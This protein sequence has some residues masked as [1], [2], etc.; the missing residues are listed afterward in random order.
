VSDVLGTLSIVRHDN[1]KTCRMDIVEGLAREHL[2]FITH[3]WS[4]ELAVAK[5]RAVL[6][7]AAL[8]QARRNEAAWQEMQRIYGAPD[9]HWDWDDISSTTGAMHR[10]L[11]LVEM[12]SVEALMRLDLS[13]PSRIETATYTPIA[14]VEYL[15]VG[16]WNRQAIQSPP[17]FK[18]LGTVMLGIATEISRGEGMSGRCGLHSLSQSEGFYRRSGMLDLGMDYTEGM[19]Y[20]EFSPET[21]SK[22][23]EG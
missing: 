1:G 16:P 22:F 15:A 23:M 21:A 13:K 5:D 3:E 10:L 7:Y 2:D 17:R 18:G 14:Y 8:P 9:S 11:A 20:F 4:S 6:A 12:S 19:T